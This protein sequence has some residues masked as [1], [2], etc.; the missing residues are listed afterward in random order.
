MNREQE[1]LLVL[2]HF[3][4]LYHFT[5]L[6]DHDSVTPFKVSYVQGCTF[7]LGVG[8]SQI[9]DSQMTSSSSSNS[10]SASRGRLYGGWSWCSSTT[11]NTEYIQVDLRQVKTV[12]GIATQGDKMLDKWTQTYKVRY[13]FDNRYWNEYAERQVTK[14]NV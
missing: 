8:N 12:T 4:V 2:Y 13:S 7:P 11:S 10:H 1:M 9:P 14:V 5:S 3:I 6:L